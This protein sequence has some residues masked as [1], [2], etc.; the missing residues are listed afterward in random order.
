MVDPCSRLQKNESGCRWRLVDAAF[1]TFFVFGLEDGHIPSYSNL[2]GAT[3]LGEGGQHLCMQPGISFNKDHITVL[4]LAYMVTH[5]AAQS[6]QYPLS[7]S[8]YL[9][10][11]MRTAPLREPISGR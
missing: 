6:T 4:T 10:V 11:V 3:A 2:L 1:P 8:T 9:P 7:D 5:L